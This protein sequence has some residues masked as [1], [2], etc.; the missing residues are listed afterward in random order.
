MSKTSLALAAMIAASALPQV[1]LGQSGA[2]SPA[3]TGPYPAIYEEVP[4]LPAHVV[5]RPADLGA[6]GT[7]KLGVYVFG[8]G[9]CS[10]DGLSSKNHLL[11]IASHGYLAIAPG[12]IPEA[13]KPLPPPAQPASG[14]LPAPTPAKALREALD[15]AV[16]ENGRS[17]SSLRGRIA[18]D[19]IALSGWSCGGLQALQNAGDPRVKSVVIMNSGIFVDGSNPIEGIEVDKGLLKTLH[20]SIL[21]VLGGPTDI[22]Y[23]NGTDDFRLITGLPAALVNIPVGHGGTFAEPNGGLAA[24]VVTAWLDWQLKG[25]PEAARQFRGKDCGYCKDPRLG[26]ERKQLDG[27]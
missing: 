19:E 20:G 17:A 7:T 1:T 21:Y 4:G 15:W 25:R 5:Y 14:K 22:A 6:L 23:P 10:A 8:N 13:G 16:A 12:A 11:E 3:G 27:P 18:T 24:Q 2:A 9:G 26:L